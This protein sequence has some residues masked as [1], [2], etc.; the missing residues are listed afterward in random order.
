MRKLHSC[1]ISRFRKVK[2]RMQ[3]LEC[4]TV[5]HGALLER[6]PVRLQ[7]ECGR[8]D[9]P[10]KYNLKKALDIP[11]AMIEMLFSAPV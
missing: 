6:S 9:I 1:L 11:G 10:L 3:E 2:K 5:P 4:Q 7:K 8:T